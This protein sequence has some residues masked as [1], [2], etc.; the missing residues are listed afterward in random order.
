[1]LNPLPVAVMVLPVDDGLLV[2]RRGIE[3]HRGGLALPGGF[4]DV[5]ES[6][7]EAAVRELREETGVVVEPDAVRLFDVHSAPDGT[8]LIFALGP[9]VAADALPP[10]AATDETMEW[11]LV[12]EPRELVFPLHTRVVAGYFTSTGAPLTE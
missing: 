4:I 7:Q 9:R 12:R 5:G 2:I 8:V 3:P 6:W 10:V 1:M 11:V